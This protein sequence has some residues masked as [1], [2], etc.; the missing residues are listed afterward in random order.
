MKY[1]LLFL[2]SFNLYAIVDEARINALT[3][4]RYSI[5]KCNYDEINPALFKEDL[6]AAQDEVKMACL[7]SYNQEIQDEATTQNVKKGQ[8]KQLRNHLRDKT[9]V[10]TD[11]E[12]D[13]ILY[14]FILKDL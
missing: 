4:F 11:E 2:I 1:L 6:I 7:E 10:L 3:D 14:H 12:R 9:R 8:M 5:A 13:K